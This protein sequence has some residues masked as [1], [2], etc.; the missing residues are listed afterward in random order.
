[1]L[2]KKPLK[3]QFVLTFILIILSGIIATIATYIVSL[4]IFSKMEYER[5]YPA[6]YYEMKIPDIEAYIREE[7]AKLLHEEEKAR[8]DKV[9]PTEGILYQVLNENGDLLY[10][11][12][13]TKVVHDKEDLHC[14]INTSFGKNGR[15]V[16]LVPVIDSDGKIA[17]AVSLSYTLTLHYKE[18]SDKRLLTPFLILVAFSPFIYIVIFTWLFSKKFTA[19]ISKPVNMLINAS[20]KVKNKD[21]DF[22][23]D[24]RADNELGRLCEA[25]NEMKNELKESLISQWMAEQ[26]RQEMVHALAHDLKTPLAVIQGYVEALLEGN[27]VDAQKTIKYLQ[28]IKDNANKASLLTK[29]M[30]YAAEIEMTGTELNITPVDINAFLM[31]KKECYEIMAKSKNIN[32][33][34][35]VAYEGQKDV[36]CF[37]DAVKLERILDNILSNSIRYV[38]E[39]GTIAISAVITRDHINF[40]IRDTGKGFSSKDLSNL[41]NKFYRGD[42]SRSSKEGHAGLGL[43]IAKRLVEMHGG[44]ITA[45]N[46]EPGGACIEFDIKFC[47]KTLLP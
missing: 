17:G 45:F 20:G 5:I 3:S 26:E 35:D 42:E 7:G 18:L 44:S 22:T 25:F 11:T 4:V 8:L 23:I 34:V 40:T 19:N 1:M 47:N 31:Q 13:D 16:R 30:L 6:N 39:Y 41:F 21:L 2:E 46:A 24:Y 38:P 9:I 12:D 27:I 15:H 43:Y 33:K 10:G 29:E 32:I 36:P 14:K 28:V 37:I